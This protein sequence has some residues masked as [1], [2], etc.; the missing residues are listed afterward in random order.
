[1]TMPEDKPCTDP[2]C[3]GDMEYTRRDPL[4]MDP[5]TWT[6]QKC[7]KVEVVDDDPGT[8]SIFGEGA[9]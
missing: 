2:K 7:G 8:G 3:C 5:P 1:M 9:D 4:S 6:C